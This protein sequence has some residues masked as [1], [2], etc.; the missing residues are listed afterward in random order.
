MR[1]FTKGEVD[2]ESQRLFK[3]TFIRALLQLGQDVLFRSIVCVLLRVLELPMSLRLVHPQRI[4]FVH[5]I[6]VL[7]LRVL[8]QLVHHVLHTIPTFVLLAITVIF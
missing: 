6:Y 3:E 8:Y 7:V 5:K 4:V 2:I 1:S